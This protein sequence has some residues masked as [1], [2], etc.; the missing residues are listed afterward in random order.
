MEI[1]IWP[2]FCIGIGREQS[3]FISIIMQ[4]K[5]NTK[6]VLNTETIFLICHTPN[7]CFITNA[8]QRVHSAQP[9][10]DVVMMIFLVLPFL[11]EILSN[12]FAYMNILSITTQQVC[13]YKTLLVWNVWQ[14]LSK[15]LYNTLCYG[16][17]SQ[18]WRVNALL[19]ISQRCGN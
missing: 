13:S 5:K 9:H 3:K 2:R 17:G 7:Q 12:L 16:S 8:S 10:T 18:L 4:F 15:T 1:Y 6:I 14:N 11:D 19:H